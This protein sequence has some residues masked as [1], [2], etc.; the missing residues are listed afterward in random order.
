LIS[1]LPT[2]QAA[3][4]QKF[5]QKYLENG[6]AIMPRN[7]GPTDR[8]VAWFVCVLLI[9]A[10]IFYVH[11]QFRIAPYYPQVFDQL[12]YIGETED[13]LKD[14]HSRGFAA[15][16]E[17]FLSPSPTGITYPVQGAVS[18]LVLGSSRASLLTVNLIYFLAAQ[19]AVFFTVM[20]SRS[21]AAAA[22]LSISILV[23]CDGIFRRAGGIADYRIDFA[24][25]CLF[26][27]WICLLIKSDQ[28][29]SRKF[30]VLAGLTAAAL[31][32]MRFITAA[33]VVPMMAALLG[34]IIFRRRSFES[35][36]Q[37][38]TN[39][40]ISCALVIVV[41][42]P[43][44]ILAIGPI[45]NYYVAGHIKGDE[46]A[47]R[48]AESG[49]YDLTGHLIFYPKALLNYQIGSIGN[50]L[51]SILLVA[52]VLGFARQSDRRSG[53]IFEML[54]VAAATVLPI[55]LLTTDVA[56]SPV[57][58]GVILIP[59]VLLIVLFWR[60]FVIPSFS[61]RALQLAAGFGLIVGLSAFIAHAAAPS[62]EFSEADLSE[63]KRLNLIIA[64]CGGEAPRIAF[65]RLTDYLNVYTVRFYL[66][67]TYQ[68]PVQVEP[69]YQE[70]LAGIFAV[71]P[72][73]A[74]RAV[75]SSDIVV[76]SDEWFKRSRFPF[77]Q[78]IIQSWPMIN[79]YAQNNLK[80]HA[81]GKIDGITYRIFVRARD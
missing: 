80:L 26:G 52:T 12:R 56:K 45:N 48:A 75:E 35:C 50:A 8:P 17:P 14:F 11:V 59:F 2:E 71:G 6:P 31:I 40:V 53:F 23:A 5:S 43:A 69:R 27:I 24:A 66:R 30:S 37:R 46:P 18:A 65:D 72:S 57:V 73:D 15:L 41:A 79:G 38:I 1:E 3:A 76:L 22:W 62:S 60:S 33:F 20:R 16:L 68:S 34:W 77:D 47:I 74:M 19:V 51:I 25:M 81:T 9:E 63:V 67:Q 78:S 64:N 54:L 10:I 32:L 29:A 58:A 36:R 21:E 13:I 61:E 55:I 70:T 39:Y 44:L 4:T 42:A 7:L 28:F 49:V